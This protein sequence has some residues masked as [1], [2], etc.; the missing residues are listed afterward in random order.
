MLLLTQCLSAEELTQLTFWWLHHLLHVSSTLSTRHWTRPCSPIQGCSPVFWPADFEFALAQNCVPACAGTKQ[1]SSWAFPVLQADYHVHAQVTWMRWA[2]ASYS[3][4]SQGIP[5]QLAPLLLILGVNFC[6]SGCQY[7]NKMQHLNRANT[8][9]NSQN[10]EYTLTFYLDI[11]HFNCLTQWSSGYPL[12]LLDTVYK[13]LMTWT[14]TGEPIFQYFPS[15]H[16]GSMSFFP[17]PHQGIPLISLG[18]YRTRCT[19]SE[20]FWRSRSTKGKQAQ[21]HT[22]K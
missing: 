21:K 2:T 9:P 1:I 10:I 6:S 5:T 18:L 13:Y 17:S 15:Y 7:R 14:L 8:T 20:W 11:S 16:E 3:K 22:S 4:P 19:F 12:K